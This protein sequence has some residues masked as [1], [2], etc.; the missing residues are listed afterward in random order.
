MNN[1]I[2]NFFK[3]LDQFQ[4]NVD[5]LAQQQDDLMKRKDQLKKSINNSSQ[6]NQKGLNKRSPL[7][8]SIDGLRKSIEQTFKSWDK[9][10]N[11]ALPMKQLTDHYQ[12]QIIF[13]IFGKVNVGKSSFA[14]FIV[15]QAG[16]HQVK[17]FHFHQG[18]IEY[19][20][21]GEQFKE[22]FTETTATIQGVE[23][24]KH[25]VLLDTPGLHSVTEV[26]GDLTR[27]FIDSADAVLWLTPSDSPGQVQELNDLKAELEKKK[28]L[29]PIITRS[30]YLDEGDWCEKTDKP[31]SVFVNKTIENRCL[32]E[33][34]VRKRLTDLNSGKKSPEVDFID[35]SCHKL[36]GSF[37][38]K[39][40]KMSVKKVMI[41]QDDISSKEKMTKKDHLNSDIFLDENSI[42]QPLSIS[43]H[44]FKQ[45]ANAG[46]SHDVAFEQAGLSYLFL[47][48]TELITEAAAY[49]SDKAKQQMENFLK[50]YILS[51]LNQKIHPL[52]KQAQNSFESALKKLDSEEKTIAENVLIATEVE[53]SDLI[54]KHKKNRDQKKLLQEINDLV[55]QKI[56]SELGQSLSDFSD[57]IETVSSQLDEQKIDGFKDKTMSFEKVKGLIA[58]SLTGSGG[59]AAGAAGGALLGSMVPVVGTIAGGVVGGVLGGLA[60]AAAGSYFVET[61]TVT[62]VIGVGSEELE[63]SLKK[64]L[65]ESVP[66]TVSA[67]FAEVKSQ[68]QSVQSACNEL[69]AEIQKFSKNVAGEGNE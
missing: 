21:Q 68:I 47:Q 40:K 36:D 60:G 32:Q 42:K 45:E 2:S 55:N 5:H 12:N 38:D 64:Q 50:E 31:I 43:I 4:T 24:G 58:Q 29:L 26:N 1:N 37:F 28:P 23:I 16:D 49:K 48:L 33:F 54:E 25:F 66:K 59:A 11:N 62:E 15:S 57:K 3:V 51:S 56:N 35:L 8:Q 67:A 19:L 20:E 61:E 53:V 7:V 44:A 34:D 69:N 27:R 9:S 65:K 14:N 63:Q 22:G 10:V 52:V 18:K 41:K 46:V 13:L 17:R 6:F 39:P 30:D